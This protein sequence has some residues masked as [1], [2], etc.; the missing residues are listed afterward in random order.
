MN[1]IGSVVCP[2]I[3]GRD[4]LLASAER[5]IGEALRGEGRTLLLAGPAGIGKTRLARAIYRKA[6]AAGLRLECGSVAPQDRK[7]IRKLLPY[8]VD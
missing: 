1:R 7:R 8:G 2:I 5:W 3:V 4:E 6:E